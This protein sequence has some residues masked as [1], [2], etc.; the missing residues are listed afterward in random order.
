MANARWLFWNAI[1]AFLWLMISH[2]TEIEK[3]ALPL[4]QG[5][6]E[7]ILLAALL[8]VLYYAVFAA[9]FKSAFYTVDIKSKV[10]DLI[11]VTLGALFVN[12]VAPTWGMAGAALYV[13]D[14]SHRGES[15][16]RAAAGTLLAQ[17]ADFSAFAL[18]LAGGIA[19]LSTQNRLQNYEIAGT[20]VLVAILCSLAFTL[21]LGQWHPILLM[22]LLGFLQSGINRL[23]KKVHRNAFFP[24]G[25]AARNAADFSNAAEAIEAHPE[26]LALTLG[27]ALAAHLINISSLYA[28]FLAFHQQ[29]EFGPLVSG[30]AMGILFWNISPVPQG[31]GV[32]EGVM[33][34]VYTSLGIHGFIAA[35]IVLAFRAL[36]FWL[37]MLLGFILLRKVKID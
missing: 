37:P 5:Q 36:N 15:P 3:A 19:Y 2:L 34:L 32:V 22:K 35:L 10:R 21:I 16:A 33:A 9:I 7:W 11:P 24:D 28:L 26:K 8:Q 13:D 30:Y 4:I 6:P 31:I 1:A 18:I 25:W 14:A 17:T 23:A 20:V 12:V 27:L 29:I